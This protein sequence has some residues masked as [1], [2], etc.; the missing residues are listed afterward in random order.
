MTLTDITT[1]C[2]GIQQ[3]LVDILHGGLQVL[4]DDTVELEGLAGGQLERPVTVFVRDLVD[5][6]P[7]FGS[8][9]TSGHTTSDHEG[10]GGLETLSFKGFSDISVVL[11]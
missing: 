2:N 6:E 5:G 10:I 1:S 11:E 9:N 7:L 8:A 3:T 4:F